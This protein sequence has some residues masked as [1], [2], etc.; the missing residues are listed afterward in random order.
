MIQASQ[1]LGGINTAYIERLNATFR[2]C[3]ASLTR[4]TRALAQQPETLQAWHVV[5]C[6]YNFAPIT[7]A[8]G[9]LSAWLKGL[10]LVTTNSGHRG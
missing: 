8:Y 2:Q 5:G 6:F 10:S 1:G 7:I 4:R 3:L 9:C